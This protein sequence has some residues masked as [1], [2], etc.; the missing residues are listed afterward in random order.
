M[1][2]VQKKVS[3]GHK[4]LRYYTT[5]AWNFKHDNFE[6]LLSE[7]SE[8]DKEKFCI[9]MNRI[10][11][12]EYVKNYIIGIRVHLANDSLDTLPKA[13]RLFNM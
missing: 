9:D 11:L 3:L 13:R 7:M 2:D 8:V 12:N 10:D 5:R 4:V 1:V 6:K